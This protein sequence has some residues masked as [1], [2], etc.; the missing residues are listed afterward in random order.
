MWTGHG[1]RLGA[2]LCGV[3][4]LAGVAVWATSIWFAVEVAGPLPKGTDFRISI[5]GGAGLWVTCS[6]MMPSRSWEIWIERNKDKRFFSDASILEHH[7][8]GFGIEWWKDSSDRV[9]NVAML[10]WPFPLCGVLA[11]A[12][13]CTAEWRRRRLSGCCKRCGYDMRATPERCP[14]CGT[15]ATGRD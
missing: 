10:L 11:T 5:G 14:E 7:A 9:L 6:N 3:L 15:V 4:T 1:R 2:V 13:F 8:A 12:G